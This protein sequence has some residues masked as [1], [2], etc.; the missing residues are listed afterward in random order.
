MAK[1]NKSENSSTNLNEFG[2]TSSRSSGSEGSLDS[3][4][5]QRSS[6]NQ[7][8]VIY[9]ILFVLALIVLFTVYMLLPQPIKY[10]NVQFNFRKYCPI[11]YE[12]RLVKKEDYFRYLPFTQETLD[13]NEE[14]FKKI[15]VVE[16]KNHFT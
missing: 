5:D 14:K 11:F 1:G 8:P 10:D 7:R 15:Y 6:K 16:V 2:S 4:P 13:L 3:A 12:Q 9:T